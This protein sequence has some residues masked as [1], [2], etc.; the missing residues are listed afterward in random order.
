[1]NV[2]FKYEYFDLF[3]ERDGTVTTNPS[4][5]F[6]KDYSQCV[7]PLSNGTGER[8]PFGSQIKSDEDNLRLQSLVDDLFLNYYVFKIEKDAKDFLDGQE[9]T[10][11][12]V[13]VENGSL[14]HRG[15]KYYPGV[16]FRKCVDFLNFFLCEGR[17]DP[18]LRQKVVDSLQE[19]SVK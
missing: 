12:H 10:M 3:H 5:M 7:K 15:Q 18:I 2:P 9:N 19:N 11:I 16:A 6:L 1:M 13:F 14:F 8:L 4:S 17:K